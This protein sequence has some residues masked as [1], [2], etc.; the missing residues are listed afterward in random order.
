MKENLIKPKKN[1][2]VPK[3]I[4]NNLTVY[5]VNDGFQLDFNEIKRTLKIYFPKKFFDSV[6]IVYYYDLNSEDKAH[7]KDQAIFI[8][9]KQCKSNKDFIKSLTHETS[10]NFYEIITRLDNF[11]RLKEEFLRKKIKILE[12]LKSNLKELQNSQEFRQFYDEFEKNDVFEDFIKQN[13]G[14]DVLFAYSMPYYPTPYSI[15]SI[16][17]YLSVGFEV[18]YLENKKWLEQFCPVLY[19]VIVFIEKVLNEKD[20]SIDNF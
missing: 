19:E 16:E 20:Q 5:Y 6:D 10:H 11:G 13:I 3:K 12:R 2:V 1:S 17:E 7:M 14:F 15:L 8:N 18:Y 9:S 4:F